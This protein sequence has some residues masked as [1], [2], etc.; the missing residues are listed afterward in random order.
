MRV[1]P[2]AAAYLRR[3]STALALLA[4]V[5]TAAGAQ[6]ASSAAELP[7]PYWAARLGQSVLREPRA[8]HGVRLSSGPQQT[9]E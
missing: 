6:P 9:P 5:T 4:A 7:E 2:R 3:A 1:L 8:S